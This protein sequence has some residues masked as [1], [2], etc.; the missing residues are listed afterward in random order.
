MFKKKRLK[1]RKFRIFETLRN[2]HETTNQ[3]D[4]TFPCLYNV[5]FFVH[6][7]M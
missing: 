6:D 1:D 2:I 3:I 7:P 5:L 4:L